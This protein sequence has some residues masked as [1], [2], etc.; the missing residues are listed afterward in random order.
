MLKYS[1][2]IKFVAFS[3]KLVIADFPFAIRSAVQINNANCF[4]VLNDF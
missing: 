1:Q 3:V 4:F 2:A